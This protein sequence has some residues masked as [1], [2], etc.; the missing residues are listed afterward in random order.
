MKAIQIFPWK[1]CDQIQML[2]NISK[3]LHLRSHISDQIKIHHAVDLMNRLHIRRLHTN[4]Q[5]DQPWPHLLHDRQFFF[6][7]QIRCNF[8]MEVRDSIIVIQD[9]LPQIHSP[10]GITVKSSIQ[11]FHLRHLCL[12][13]KSQFLL[14]QIKAS[15]SKLLL[16]RRQTVRAAERST[17]AGLVIDNLM[18]EIFQVIID[19]RKF[20]HIGRSTILIDLKFSLIIPVSDTGNRLKGTCSFYI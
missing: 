1:S 18:R 10:P 7:D 8:K 15:E 11:E 3:A 12:Q 5:L 4:L 19:K 14:H 9:P 17:S 16:Q 13:E 6:R 20:I 2:V